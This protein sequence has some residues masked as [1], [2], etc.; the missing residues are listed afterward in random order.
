MGK[1]DLKNIV[2]EIVDLPTLPQIAK[3]IIEMADNEQTSAREIN[4][5]LSRDPALA[6]KILRLV[7]STCYGLTHRISNLNQAIVILGFKTIRSVALGVSVA[8]LFGD[9]KNVRFDREQFWKHSIACAGINKSVASKRGDIDP[10]FAHSFGLLHDIG[11]LAIDEYNRTEMG[12]II[13]MAEE[14]KI[15]FFEAE[16][17]VLTTTHAEIGGWL[18]QKWGMQD[19]LVNAIATHH[20]IKDSSDKTLTA[21]NIFANYLCLLKGLQA[22]GSFETP[23]P[24]GSIWKML[25]LTKA[26]LPEIINIIN[27][28]MKLSESFL[29]T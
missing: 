21:I 18:A 12:R 19:Q 13:D 27:E 10:E 1:K 6:S 20:D 9:K 15:S 5:L 11:K 16:K 25:K 7:N 3:N 28:E 8:G 24:D 26:D 23:I 17:G 29:K 22:S 2:S 4:K 14:K